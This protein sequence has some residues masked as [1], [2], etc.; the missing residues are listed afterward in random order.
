MTNARF[1]NLPSLPK[2]PGYTHVVEAV[3]PGR[4][5][6]ISG[7]LGQD[8]D[9]KLG[10]DFRAQCVQVFENLDAALRLVGANFR[11]VVK[12]NNYLLDVRADL[13]TFREIRDRYV[14][15]TSPP[16]GTTIQVPALARAGALLEVEA[17]AL[18]PVQ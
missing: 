16:A 1:H 12:L 17:I 5:V 15:T 13:H 8:R 14:D 11:H 10:T 3:G 9:G 7:Q 4:L 6:F 2:P 18:L